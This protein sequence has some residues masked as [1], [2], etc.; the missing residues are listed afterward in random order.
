M[1][2]TLW[3]LTQPLSAR[4][5]NAQP[6]VNYRPPIDLIDP[7]RPQT[8]DHQDE[9]TSDRFLKLRSPRTEQ[10]HSVYKKTHWID[11]VYPLRNAAANQSIRSKLPPLCS[12]RAPL[13]TYQNRVF[14]PNQRNPR[15]LRHKSIKSPNAKCA[16]NAT[17]FL[18][19]H[20]CPF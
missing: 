13:C 14:S 12:Y 4:K 9:S 10:T 7:D 18:R 5:K 2:R 20:S 16:V 15:Y 17:P 11:C 19:V 1:S 8:I 6:A 3:P